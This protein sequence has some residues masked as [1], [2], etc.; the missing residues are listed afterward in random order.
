MTFSF[1]PNGTNPLK[2]ILGDSEPG[3]GYKNRTR[4]ISLAEPLKNPDASCFEKKICIY[5][6]P[7]YLN[8]N[9]HENVPVLNQ[10]RA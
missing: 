8:K 2:I 3:E 4:I 5:R 7:V 9:S 10:E 1:P 6:A